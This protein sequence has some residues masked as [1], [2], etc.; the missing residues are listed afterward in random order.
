MF[1]NIKPFFWGSPRKKTT[2]WNPSF[3][4][5]V[6]RKFLGLQS[7]PKHKDFDMTALVA[8]PKFWVIILPTQVRHAQHRFA[9]QAQPQESCRYTKWS[10]GFRCQSWGKAQ[11]KTPNKQ[12]LSHIKGEKLVI[13]ACLLNLHLDMT[14][15]FIHVIQIEMVV[16]ALTNKEVNPRS[17]KVSGHPKVNIV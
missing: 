16:H 12:N 11:N 1:P 4:G 8:G 10:Y 6:I 2:N 17:H 9:R 5:V 7:Y 13:F 14:Q 3:I 15:K